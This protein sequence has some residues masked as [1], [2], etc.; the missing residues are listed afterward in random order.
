MAQ[1]K[2]YKEELKNEKGG[3]VFSPDL[4]DFLVWIFNNID[5]NFLIMNSA[6]HSS[7]NVEKIDKIW[8]VAGTV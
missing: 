5:S 6:C 4:E 7:N 2:N 1:Q 8:V 3:I